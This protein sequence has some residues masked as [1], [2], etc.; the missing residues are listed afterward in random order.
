MLPGAEECE[1]WRKRPLHGKDYVYLW[2]DGV[3]F[4]I[5]LEEEKLACLVLVGVLPDG[6]QGSDRHRGW[7]PG[8]QGVLGFSS[9]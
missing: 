1:T 8:I 6:D 5:R 7:L 3:Y 2:A 9:A 4:G